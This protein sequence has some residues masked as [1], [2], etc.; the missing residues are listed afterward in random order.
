MLPP[1]S[2]N[3]QACFQT[4][5]A[6]LPHPKERNRVHVQSLLALIQHAFPCTSVIL[7]E[8]HLV[9]PPSRVH[10]RASILH[11]PPAVFSFQVDLPYSDWLL[12]IPK[13]HSRD[14]RA[15]GNS[16]PSTQV[17]KQTH[18]PAIHRVKPPLIG[19][20]AEVLTASP[21]CQHNLPGCIQP[22]LHTVFGLLLTVSSGS[23]T[24]SLP[25]Q[26]ALTLAQ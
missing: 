12:R 24:D 18:A 7:T 2:H 6:P 1:I 21:T 25:P 11:L 26:M 10:H 3:P 4:C 5:S 15:P 20:T 16:A 23:P 17:H 14:W 8:Q 13:L 9:L 19:F 22:A